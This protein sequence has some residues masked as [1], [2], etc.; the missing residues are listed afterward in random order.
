VNCFLP[1]FQT[2][3]ELLTKIFIY[4]IN[5]HTIL[6]ERVMCGLSKPDP[7]DI[8]ECRE[9]NKIMDKTLNLEIQNMFFLRFR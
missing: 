7:K 2:F 4:S 1:F 6:K 3:D 5:Q 9:S 8:I